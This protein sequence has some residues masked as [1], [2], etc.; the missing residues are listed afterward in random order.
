MLTGANIS[1]KTPWNSR[2]ISMAH[3]PSANDYSVNR[4]LTRNRPLG[5]DQFGNR[6]PRG[7]TLTD[8]GVLSPFNRVT[9]NSVKNCVTNT[10]N[11]TMGNCFSNIN[12]ENMATLAHNFLQTFLNSG[13]GELAHQ[14][15]YNMYSM[16]ADRLIDGQGRGSSLTIGL[17]GLTGATYGLKERFNLF[18]SLFTTAIQTEMHNMFGSSKNDFAML[19]SNN[20]LDNGTRNVNE[21]NGLRSL[22][23]QTLLGAIKHVHENVMQTKIEPMITNANGVFKMGSNALAKAQKSIYKG[24]N[25]GNNAPTDT[26]TA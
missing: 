2:A 19:S 7:V 24:G 10:F 6:F 9:G 11:A 12:G 17:A 13:R 21:S 23:L 1:A 15:V 16:M 22:N 18:H 8:G 5:F 4:N 20:P 3:L 26:A 14:Y 25:S